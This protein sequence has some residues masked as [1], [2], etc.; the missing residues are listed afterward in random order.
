MKKGFLAICALLITFSVSAKKHPYKIKIVTDSGTIELV[1]YNNTPLNRDNMLKLAKQ[2]AYDS[3]LFHR[4]IPKFMIQ[5]GDPTSKYAKLSE[6]LG[7]GGLDY[8]VPAEINDT[9]FHKRGALGVARDGNKEK[10]GSSS[11]FY[12]VTGKTFTD[13]ELD[14][15][16]ARSHHTWTKEQREIYKTEGGAPH[17]DGDYTV[18]GEVTK[19]MDVVDKI[20]LVP[21]EPG[22]RPKKD[23]RIIKLRIKKRHRFLFF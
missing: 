23:I 2:H 16:T 20:S 14:K 21:R 19:G 13:D 17:L 6:H 11:Q 1:L 5:G 18:F 9:D 12:I 15:I 22:D 3:L 10:A 7:S 8:T 4:V